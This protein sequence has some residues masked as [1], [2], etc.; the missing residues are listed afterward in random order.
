MGVAIA[1][2]IAAGVGATVGVA[3]MVQSSVQRKRAE[4]MQLQK[5][6]AEQRQNLEKIKRQERAMRTGIA[7]K[8][9]VEAIDKVVSAVGK[10]GI[11]SSGGAGGAAMA[12]TRRAMMMG[13]EQK[14]AVLSDLRKQALPL[15]A[16]ITE[17]T[18][19][20]QQRKDEITL[21]ERAKIE[22]RAE[23]NMKAGQQNFMAGVTTAAG[24][25]GGG[26]T[27]GGNVNAVTKA[28][29]SFK[30]NREGAGDAGDL[31]MGGFDLDDTQQ[32]IYSGEGTA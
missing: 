26:A 24:A 28:I 22:A 29:N 5:E 17:Q 1:G 11:R 30:T 32:N 7:A 27:G 23:Q 3:Q 15:T 20:I 6:S 12:S 9:D 19:A 21:M 13:G 18:N 31:D 10:A 14:A 16:M 4:K 25:Y 8:R 2:I